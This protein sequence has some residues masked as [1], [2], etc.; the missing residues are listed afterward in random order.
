MADLKPVPKKDILAF[1]KYFLKVEEDSQNEGYTRGY[2]L[3]FESSGA[4]D[5]YDILLKIKKGEAELYYKPK[6]KKVI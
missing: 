1:D 2:D 3:K 6:L 4:M 5:F